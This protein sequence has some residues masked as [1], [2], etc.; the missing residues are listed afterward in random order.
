[1][2]KDIKLV[3]KG[4][5]YVHSVSESTSFYQCTLCGHRHWCDVK[6]RWF[7]IPKEREVE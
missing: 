3:C 2:E 1:M 4:C 5:G 7:D 6:G